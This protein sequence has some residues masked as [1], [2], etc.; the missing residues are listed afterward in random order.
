MYV[1]APSQGSFACLHSKNSR[2][3]FYHQRNSIVI[4]LSMSAPIHVNET[5][6]APILE[7][8]FRPLIWL[9]R[10]GTK[11]RAP[12]PDDGRYLMP[13]SRPLYSVLPRER[14]LTAPLLQQAHEEQL[15]QTYV[16]QQSSL[17]IKVP[18][19]LRRLIW[20]YCLGGMTLHVGIRHDLLESRLSHAKCTIPQTTLAD[21]HAC[22]G[23]KGSQGSL[24]SILLSCRQV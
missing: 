5:V 17:L 10:R 24:I 7:F 6:I 11:R 14:S 8:V 3:N 1:Q 18:F 12:L 16:Q 15:Q 21:W 22:W 4:S 9:V 2:I 13:P 23:T 20:E 19:D